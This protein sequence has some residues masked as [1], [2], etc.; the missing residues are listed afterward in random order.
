MQQE[1]KDLQGWVDFLSHADLP[2][3]KQTAR[4]LASLQA[5]EKN[6][7]AR[8]VAQIIARD[9]MMT[10]KL[11]RYLQQHKHKSQLSEVI[12]VEQALLMIG[13]EH[14]FLHVQ[15]EPLVEEVLHD[16]IDALTALLRVVHRS[17][18]ASTYAREWAARLHDMHYEEARIAALLHELAE[19]LLW[20]FAPMSM[21]Q[22][23]AVQQQDKAVRSRVAQEAVLGF[24]L[25]DLQKALAQKWGLPELLL[26]LM[27]ADCA[28]QPRVRNVIIAVNLA[29]HSAHGWDNAAL[30]DD[31]KEAAE[32]L[33]LTPE[34]IMVLVGAESVAT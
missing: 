28:R 32:L 10:V 21:L 6:L 7:S 33:R 34:Q 20:C 5:D 2:V 16:H 22:V 24:N 17:H 14:F 19:V 13:V 25:V 18:R 4:D 8:S 1:Q 23:L 15:A 31:Y 11:L 3:L 27:D 9:P 26:T 12:E 30:P 29:R